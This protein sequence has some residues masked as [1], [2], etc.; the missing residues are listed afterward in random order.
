MLAKIAY[1]HHMLQTWCNSQLKK[2]LF[3]QKLFES[4]SLEVT[5]QRFAERFPVRRPP[6]FGHVEGI[7]A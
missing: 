2:E 3:S 7:G 1:F 5:C 4:G 6:A